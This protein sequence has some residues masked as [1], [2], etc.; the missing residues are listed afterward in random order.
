MKLFLFILSMIAIFTLMVLT[1]VVPPV[2]F[3]F[4]FGVP[5]NPISI[6]F[7]VLAWVILLGGIR[8]FGDLYEV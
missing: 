1:L 2:V 3:M 6:L 4:L 5:I 7:T 8:K